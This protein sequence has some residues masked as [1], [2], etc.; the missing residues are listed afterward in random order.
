MYHSMNCRGE[1]CCVI[2]YGFE[3]TCVY[4][5]LQGYSVTA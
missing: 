1:L 5:I 2:V 4:Q 3:M